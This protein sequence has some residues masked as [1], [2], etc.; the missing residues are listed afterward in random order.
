MAHHK[1]DANVAHGLDIGKIS[2]NNTLDFVRSKVAIKLQ[3]MV[4]MFKK[5]KKQIKIGR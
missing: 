2:V 5:L 4:D 3:K 1:T